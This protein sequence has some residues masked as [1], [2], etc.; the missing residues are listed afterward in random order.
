MY[1]VWEG[2]EPDQIG[3]SLFKGLIYQVLTHH[4]IE[5]ADGRLWNLSKI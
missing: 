1:N 4:L 5:C 2:Q 3:G